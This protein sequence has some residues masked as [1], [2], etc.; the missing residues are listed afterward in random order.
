MLD[1]DIRR[2]E[3]ICDT[4]ILPVRAISVNRIARVTNVIRDKYI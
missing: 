2:Y 3:L 1:A 4:G